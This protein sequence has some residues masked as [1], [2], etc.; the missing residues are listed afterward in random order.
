MALAML[1]IFDEKEMMY[2]DIIVQFS[3]MFYFALDTGKIT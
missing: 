3:M 2:G 1:T